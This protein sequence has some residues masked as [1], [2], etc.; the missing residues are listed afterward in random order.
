M[1]VRMIMSAVTRMA[2]HGQNSNSITSFGG[3]FGSTDSPLRGADAS[4]GGGRRR[5]SPK[6]GI[7]RRKDE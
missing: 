4:F 3:S 7:E 1:A 6:T 2:A 5:L